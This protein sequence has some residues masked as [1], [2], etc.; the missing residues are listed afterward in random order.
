MNGT[1]KETYYSI[2]GVS[3]NANMNEIKKAYRS[4]SFKY[5]PDKN[6]GNKEKEDVYK[7]INQ[8]YDTLKDSSKRQQYDFE[9]LLNGDNMQQID[10]DMGDMFGQLFKGLQKSRSSPSMRRQ[11]RTHNPYE[12]FMFMQFPMAPPQAQQATPPVTQQQQ[13]LA[14]EDIHINHEITLEDAYAG[15]CVPMNV[16][17]ETQKNNQVIEEHETLYIDIPPGI[18]HNE[19]ITLPGKGNVCEDKQSDVK[20]HIILKPHRHFHRVGIDLY[21]TH[22]VSFKDSLLGFF[23]MVQH[24]NGQNIK[25][26]NPKGHVIMNQTE[27]VLKEL[28]FKRGEKKGNLILKFGVSA[29]ENLTDEQLQKLEDI[30]I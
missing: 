4:L 6:P 23:F 10:L 19:I 17:R 25:L 2:L 20:I 5:H 7:K 21:Y 30:F 13:T 22:D 27:K 29:P 3:N 8:A 26:S 12:D 28:G 9:I 11:N 18:D 24:I 15:L 16:S 14:V 1:E